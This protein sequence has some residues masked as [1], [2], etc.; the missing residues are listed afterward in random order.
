MIFEEKPAFGERKPGRARKAAARY[1]EQAQLF[2]TLIHTDRRTLY[3]RFPG[4]SINLP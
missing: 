4:A 3:I 2:G 1:L